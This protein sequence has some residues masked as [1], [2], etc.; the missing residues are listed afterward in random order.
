MAATS[1]AEAK[2]IVGGPRTRREWGG[3]TGSINTDT[4]LNTCVCQGSSQQPAGSWNGHRRADT[5]SHTQQPHTL[6]TNQARFG[7][8]RHACVK[9]RCRTQCERGFTLQTEQMQDPQYQTL[10]SVI[11]RVTSQISDIG[12]S[13]N[14]LI[15]LT[16]KMMQNSNNI[17]QKEA[18]VKDTDRQN[19]TRSTYSIKVEAHK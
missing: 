4:C 15:G 17:S 18:Y 6:H 11:G 9:V 7:V 14:Q 5:G 16:L 13:K 3:N 1:P 8:C 12:S 19:A 10:V 2:I